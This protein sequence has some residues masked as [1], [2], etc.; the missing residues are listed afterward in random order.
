MGALGGDGAFYLK[1]KNNKENATNLQQG[2]R[3]DL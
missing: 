2:K 3:V 1:Q